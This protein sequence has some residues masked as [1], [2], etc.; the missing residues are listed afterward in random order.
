M[1]HLKKLSKV[2]HPLDEFLYYH[3]GLND[4]MVILDDLMAAEMDPWS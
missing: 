1:L 2:S 3:T 4:V